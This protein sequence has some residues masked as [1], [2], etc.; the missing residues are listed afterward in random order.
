MHCSYCGWQNGTSW[1]ETTL[2]GGKTNEPI[3]L[4]LLSY[5]GLKASGSQLVSRK[6]HKIFKKFC[7]Y[8]LKVFW[9]DLNTCLGLVLPAIL[10]NGRIEA[11]F[12]GDT[13]S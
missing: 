9:V 1:A 12:W 11:G 8:L 5:A 4:A 2:N 7:S 6:F 3:A 10:L 13:L